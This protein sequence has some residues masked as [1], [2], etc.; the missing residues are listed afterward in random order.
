MRAN[1][2]LIGMLSALIAAGVAAQDAAEKDKL[3]ANLPAFEE[4][5]TDGDKVLSWE[6]AK[7][8]GVP[9]SIFNQEDHD[10]DGLITKPT[11]KYAIKRRA[12]SG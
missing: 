12:E 5:N 2:A 3:P 11:Y 4:A 9:R 10:N 7:A 8:I 6:E 1:R